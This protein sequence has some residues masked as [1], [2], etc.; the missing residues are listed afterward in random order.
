MALS[1]TS[2][3]RSP[4]DPSPL[5]RALALGKTPIAAAALFSL[6]TNLLYL[7]LPLYTTQIYS[8]VLMSQSGSTLIVLTVGAA[9]VFLVSSIIDHFRAQVLTSFGVV[10]DS[11]M[12]S[13]TFAALFDAVVR[14][15]GNRAQALRDLDTVRQNLTGGSIGVLFDLPWI[16][17]FLILLF[18]VDGTIGAVTTAGGI[19]LLGL[20]LLQDRA[21]HQALKS[22]G[23][24]Q[25]QSYSFTDA[26]LR[27]G[28][29]V[30]ALGMLPTLG[31]HWLKLR[32]ESI[33]AAVHA[34]N[35]AAFYAGMIRFVRMGIQ[36]IIIALGAW[37]VINRSIPAGLLFANMILSSRALA[38]I[39]RAV[40]SWK[41]MFDAVQAYKR[42]DTALSDY[43]P[44]T[45]V[46]QLPTPT[47]K[48]QVQGL[49]FAPAGAAALVLL[50][51]S[52]D[53]EPGEIVGVVGPSGAGKSTLARI[54]VGIWKANSGSVR[55][56]GAE[57]YYWDR[58]DFG[59]HVS[60]QPQETELFAGS[61]RNNI[62]RFQSDAS[63]EDIVK[64]AQ[65][66]GAHEMILRLPNGYDTEL[67]EGGM[68][69]SSGQRQRVGLARTLFGDPK[70]VVLDE[71]N[72]N[73][74]QEGDAALARAI[75]EMKQRGTTIIVISHKPALIE[76]ADKVLVLRP[77]EPFLYGRREEILRP[78]PAP[79]AQA[80]PVAPPPPAVSA[81]E[82][83]S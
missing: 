80:R 62:A 8:R 29:V 11:Q 71:P 53:V 39:E 41:S 81:A 4:G 66:A 40:A 43:E 54:L 67:T 36:I 23:E 3:K 28:D 1:P 74:D 31:R 72:A 27:N 15:K 5:R 19:V 68:S 42:L 30:R 55:L 49:N 59:R 17:I 32:R 46:T 78:R 6:V 38:P 75:V 14:R 65:L 33:N 77:G 47:G 22:A 57:V 18:M 25:I 83:K 20:A 7:A 58:E 60:Y 50:N 64:A 56:D 37:L 51:V 24:K 16:P 12:A 52:F 34:G 45:P 82:A 79:G 73:L 69:L 26:A 61:V 9:F 44:P 21:T 35:S 10:F 13:L 48:L 70:M 2:S 63:D 76:H